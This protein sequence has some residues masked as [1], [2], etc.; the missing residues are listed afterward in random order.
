MPVS[1]LYLIQF[2]DKFDPAWKEE[3]RGRRAELLRYVPDDA[4][5]ARLVNVSLED[6]RALPFVQWVGEYRPEH[7]LHGLLRNF[8]RGGN[9]LAEAPEVSI[10]FSPMATPAGVGRSACA[11]GQGPATIP[12]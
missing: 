2:T 6:L 8:A 5:V 7:K 12:E 10:L 11:T 4:Y 9:N 1:G 3:L